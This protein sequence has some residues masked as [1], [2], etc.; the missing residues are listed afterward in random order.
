MRESLLLFKSESNII[1]TLALSLIVAIQRDRSSNAVL[2][3]V[4]E[5]QN[6]INSY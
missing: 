6:S 5:L 4:N 3:E 1:F 2:S